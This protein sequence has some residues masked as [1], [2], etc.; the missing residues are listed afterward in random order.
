MDPAQPHTVQGLTRQAY[1]QH[2]VIELQQ[3]QIDLLLKMTQQGGRQSLP[4][5]LH[6]LG[7]TVCRNPACLLWLLGHNVSFPTSPDDAA[8]EKDFQGW[9]QMP[10]SLAARQ[11]VAALPACTAAATCEALAQLSVWFRRLK[12]V[13]EIPPDFL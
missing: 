6:L 9:L 5:M 2:L 4:L 11:A 3:A 12:E 7:S 8:W 10:A 1:E 13:A